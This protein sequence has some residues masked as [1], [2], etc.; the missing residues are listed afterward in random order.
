MN[1]GS[2][3]MTRFNL[4]LAVIC[5]ALGVATAALAVPPNEVLLNGN[6]QT[7][8][9]TCCFSFGETVTVME[10]KVVVPV[11]VTWS[12]DYRLTANLFYNI[13]ISVNGHPCLSSDL[14]DGFAPPDGTFQSRSFQWT[15]LPSDGLIRG[16]NTITLC[17]GGEVA[18]DTITLAGNTL[19]VRF[20][21]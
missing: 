17:G 19:A 11:V 14:I 3:S 16:T 21:K 12:T 7:F 10:P 15:I 5:V 8:T 1:T 9:G 20:S 6:P 18:T 4:C 13:G 2:E